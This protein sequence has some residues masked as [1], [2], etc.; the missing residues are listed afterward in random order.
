MASKTSV[1]EQLTLVEPE[2]HLC[3]VCDEPAGSVSE[4][5]G[6]PLLRDKDGTFHHMKCKPLASVNLSLSYFS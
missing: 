6:F 5:T 4:G 3:E 2:R 1:A